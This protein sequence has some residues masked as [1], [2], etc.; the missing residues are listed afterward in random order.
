MA[1]AVHEINHNSSLLPG[2]KLGYRIMDSCDH[3]HTSLRAL[4]SL[5]SHSKHVGYRMKG[6]NMGGETGKTNILR[7]TE[8]YVAMPHHLENNGNDMTKNVTEEKVDSSTQAKNFPSCLSDSPVPAVI[9]LASSSPTRA[10]AQ[11]FG[12]FDLPLVR[13]QYI[14]HTQHSYLISSP[15]LHYLNFS[16]HHIKI[17]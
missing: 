13:K 17:I 5:V 1:F 7:T 2:L 15:S 3:I 16:I 14:R 8:V 12:P 4:L 9:G 10:V 11:T 6:V